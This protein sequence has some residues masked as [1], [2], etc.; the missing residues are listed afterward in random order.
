[1]SSQDVSSTKE[2]SS[3]D[4]EV[5]NIPPL[6]GTDEDVMEAERITLPGKD[7]GLQQSEL[8]EIQKLMN[9]SKPQPTKVKQFSQRLGHHISNYYFSVRLPLGIIADVT[10]EPL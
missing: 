1:M 9:G 4:Q 5:I 3:I 10:P 7:K 2:I 6:S 8:F